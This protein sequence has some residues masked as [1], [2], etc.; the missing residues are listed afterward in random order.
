VIDSDAPNIERLLADLRPQLHR[1]CARMV[2]SAVDG[3]DV[4]SASLRSFMRLP[5]LQR[6]TVILKDV[7]DHSLDEVASI[8][9]ASEAAAK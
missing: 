4:V 8:C 3:E 7:L 1:Y 2:G 9:D 5:T 6:A